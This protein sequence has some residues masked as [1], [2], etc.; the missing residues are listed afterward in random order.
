MITCE[1]PSE[2]ISHLQTIAIE[3]ENKFG[4]PIVIR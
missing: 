4:F 2:A 1:E 3:Y